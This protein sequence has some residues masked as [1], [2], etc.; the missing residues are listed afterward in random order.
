MRSLPA[1]MSCASPWSLMKRTNCGGSY[2]RSCADGLFCRRVQCALTL[3]DRL[4][5]RIGLLQI[6]APV[7][8]FLERDRDTGHRTTDKGTRPHD[9]EIAVEILYF[10]LT[11]HRRGA[12]IT[13]KQSGLL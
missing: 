5:R 3:Q 4:R 12:I 9:T 2:W 7:L 1:R 8:E 6:D 13:I 11:I 10:R